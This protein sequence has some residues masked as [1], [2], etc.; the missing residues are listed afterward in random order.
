MFKRLILIVGAIACG[1]YFS[2]PH[3]RAADVP[4]KAPAYLTYPTGNG[5][6][7]GVSAAG[8]GGSTSTSGAIVDSS[9]LIGEKLGIDAGYT[10]TIGNTFYFVENSVS[11]Q[12]VQGVTNG[13]SLS[14]IWSIEQRVA[15]GLSPALVQMFAGI[16]PG[17]GDIAMPSVPALPGALA[18]GASAPYVFGALYEDDVSA[19]FGTASGRSW[20]LSYGAGIGLLTRVS[21]GMMV[22]TSVEWKHGSGGLSIGASPGGSIKPFADSYLAT[23]RLKF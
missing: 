2:V 18:Y 14:A 11:A 9:K 5:W 8:L 16:V 23:V 12:A 13:L 20:L 6:F 17:L 3:A 22:D 7:W 4:A 1:A 15:L 19:S 10:G 21:N